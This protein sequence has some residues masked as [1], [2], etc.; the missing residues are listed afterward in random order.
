MQ[1]A[2]SLAMLLAAAAFP[3]TLPSDVSP[4][5]A[6]H[7]FLEARS[8][9]P[10]STHIA[11]AAS[12]A[13]LEPDDESE[14]ERL[15]AKAHDL[16]DLTV[17]GS[18]PFRFRASL[19]FYDPSGDSRIPPVRG[20]YVF[21]WAKPS[22]WREDAD[23]LHLKQIEIANGST[24]WTKRNAPYPSF[25]YWWTRHAIGITR[26]VTYRFDS[27]TRVEISQVEGRNVVCAKNGGAHSQQELCLDTATALPLVQ[28]DATLHLQ[29]LYSDWTEW[30]NRWYPRT[31]RAF[32]GSEPLL[33]IE[34]ANMTDAPPES[35]WL[36][37]PEGAASRDW[38]ADMRPARLNDSIENAT[39]PDPIAPPAGTTQIVGAIVYGLIGKD[40]SW[41]DLSVLE[42]PDFKA[43]YQMLEDQ[44]QFRNQPATCHGTPVES[45][46]I[47]RIS[48][49]P[50]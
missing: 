32:S 5:S 17:A 12:G 34:I 24:L 4:H 41:L 30:Q 37:P 46:L 19:F 43:A 26:G 8:A 3:G 29:I 21:T 38:C 27:Y 31:I 48:P 18:V 47:F 22:E 42:S 1:R 33:R 15:V 11:S 44:R 25:G 49:P 39:L 36:A 23:L 6:P 50:R 16:T 9:S 45:E 40:G 20:S 35:K 28:Y 10:T 2:I 7:V 14:T 13:A